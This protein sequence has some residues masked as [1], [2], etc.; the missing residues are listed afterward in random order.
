MDFGEPSPRKVG[1]YV[2]IGCVREDADSV[3]MEAT[4]FITKKKYFCKIFPRKCIN[5]YTKLRQFKE[6]IRIRQ[7][8]RHSN[9]IQL[10]DLLKDDDFYYI[11]LEFTPNGTLYDII[12]SVLFLTEP[13]TQNIMMQIFNTVQFVHSLGVAHRDLSLES[14]VID[15]YGQIKLCGFEMAIFTSK[16]KK[17][18]A[19][20]NTIGV[21]N[22]PEFINNSEVDPKLCDIWSIGIILYILLTGHIPWKAQ[23]YESLHKEM[24]CGIFEI[25]ETVSEEATDLIRKLTA[26]DPEKRITLEDAM[27]HPWMKSTLAFKKMPI[28]AGISISRVDEFLSYCDCPIKEANLE[29]E[30]NYLCQSSTNISFNQTSKIISK[31]TVKGSGSLPRLMC[32]KKGPPMQAKS[33]NTTPILPKKRRQSYNYRLF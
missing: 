6:S 33:T 16:D 22:A 5:S 29:L 3:V 26:L 23:N 24:S 20:I 4:N 9:I 27:R 2:L 1:D 11:I 31:P 25:P 21:Y 17:Y 15:I 7:Q 10:I 28:P 8:M 19:D 14:F 30:K 18:Y 12:K 13:Q 32:L